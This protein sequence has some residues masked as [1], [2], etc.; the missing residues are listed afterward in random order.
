MF[1]RLAFQ[2]LLTFPEPILFRCQARLRLLQLLFELIA[3][4]RCFLN[5]LLSRFDFSDSAFVRFQHVTK[6]DT[7]YQVYG[8]PGLIVELARCYSLPVHEPV[9]VARELLRVYEGR[10]KASLTRCVA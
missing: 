7:R 5:P 4:F 2:L 3:L 8:R 9:E 6:V 1:L 10:W